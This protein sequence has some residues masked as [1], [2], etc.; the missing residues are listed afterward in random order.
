MEINDAVQSLS[1]LAH[2]HRLEVF[3]LLVRYGADGL[4]AGE[5]AEHIG[6]PNNT[7]SSHL[8]ILSRAGLL[9]ADRR[10]R[11]IIYSVDFRG[12][13]QVLQFLLEDCCQAQPAQSNRA[14]NLAIGSL[15]VANSTTGD[16]P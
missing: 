16:T 10:G 12:I 13:K 8:S 14:L 7:L 11:R 6:I 2:T 4:A 5:I 1:A 15:S 3:R 9:N